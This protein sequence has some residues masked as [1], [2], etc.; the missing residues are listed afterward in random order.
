MTVPKILG[1]GVAAL[2]AALLAFT[3]APVPNQAVAAGPTV[4]VL[5]APSVAVVGQAIHVRAQVAPVVSGATAFTEVYV[6]GTW[7]RSQQT[8]TN[9][10][11]QFTLP[12]TYGQ[13]Q[14]GSIWFRTGATI[15]GV[16]G[17]SAEFRVTRNPT[18]SL[19]A[20]QGIGLVG[21][22]LT[23]RA[24]VN[25][26][27]AGLTGFLEAYVGTRWVRI[28]TAKTGSTGLFT[29]PLS[30]GA[31]TPGTY[32]YRLGTTVN[33]RTAY[34]QA[35]TVVRT[36]GISLMS[37]P[38]VVSV[39][40]TGTARGRTAPA[41]SGYTGFVQVWYGDHW[42]RIATARTNSAGDFTVPLA[43]GTTQAGSY[44]FRLGAT[45]GGQVF[46]SNAFTVARVVTAANLPGSFAGFTR[47]MEYGAGEWVGAPQDSSSI[48]YWYEGTLNG[49]Y[50]SLIASNVHLASIA[51]IDTREFTSVATYGSSKCGLWLGY[52]TACFVPKG[53]GFR[54]VQI[55]NTEFG[56]KPTHSQV[57]N[58][59]LALSRLT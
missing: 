38:R 22:N 1:R 35:F 8:V 16:T 55:G 12:L 18:I 47:Y 44:Q 54:G 24:Q 58:L 6:N 39:G 21:A 28:A 17:R 52:Y 41:R 19:Q 50:G 40:V 9:S 42:V 37:A 33:G 36:A 59:A 43:Y 32:R 29:V 23:A 30:Y 27:A 53:N 26:R 25:P 51:A 57:L 10:A 7:R 3:L 11:G 34:S 5:S 45:I 56:A 49:R 48:A 2:A 4:T 14:A 46:Y 13:G 20:A 15:G 31:S